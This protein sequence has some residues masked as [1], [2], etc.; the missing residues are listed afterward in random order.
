M[1]LFLRGRCSA[2]DDERE[3][4]GERDG[5]VAPSASLSLSHCRRATGRAGMAEAPLAVAMMIVD[6]TGRVTRVVTCSDFGLRNGEERGV[7]KKCVQS[8]RD[9]PHHRQVLE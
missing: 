2:D 5:T 9:P 3:E 7:R 6:G 8:R 1:R 4:I